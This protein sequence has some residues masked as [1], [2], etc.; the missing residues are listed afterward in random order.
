MRLGCTS[1]H[2][3][4]IAKRSTIYSTT[5]TCTTCLFS[6]VSYTE[7]ICT[8]LLVHSLCN[9]LLFFF[10]NTKHNAHTA[11]DYKHKVLILRWMPLN[12]Q[13]EGVASQADLH[14]G[15][16]VSQRGPT[17]SALEGSVDVSPASTTE[18]GTPCGRRRAAAARATAQTTSGSRA[19]D[20]LD[21]GSAPD[22]P[23]TSCSHQ[24]GHASVLRQQEGGGWCGSDRRRG[25]RRSASEYGDV[26]RTGMHE[27]TFL[28]MGGV[29]WNGPPKLACY[30]ILARLSL[31]PDRLAEIG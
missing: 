31:D 18:H 1:E 30:T 29:G 16:L 7:Y 19:C 15:E 20:G 25:R 23:G 17:M 21:D 28:F 26:G 8:K 10:S 14:S 12:S 9:K 4:A 13:L 24:E 22:A 5:T 11:V 6:L 2:I 3:S 27:A